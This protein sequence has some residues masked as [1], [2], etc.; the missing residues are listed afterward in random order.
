MAKLY[1][2]ATVGSMGTQL[3]GPGVSYPPGADT[4]GLFHV[5]A[6]IDRHPSVPV[7]RMVASTGGLGHCQADGS[8]RCMW[9]YTTILFPKYNV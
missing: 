2:A 3:Q 9:D 6:P 5:D 8:R 1:L 4:E 7:A